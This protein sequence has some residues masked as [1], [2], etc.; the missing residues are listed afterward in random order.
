MKFGN[1]PVTFVYHL[2]V[3]CTD[4]DLLMRSLLQNGKDLQDRKVIVPRPRTYRREVMEALYKHHGDPIPENEQLA[5]YETILKGY[6]AERVILGDQ[7][8]LTPPQGVFE[9]TQL[10]SK[11]GFRSMWLRYLF[12]E[13]P[14]EFFLAIRNPASYLPAAMRQ[15]NMPAY[16]TFV[17]GTDPRKMR[18]TSVV[19]RI[20]KN[21]PD[22][23]IVVWCNE[24]TPL[25]WPKVLREI[26]GTEAEYPF[27]ADHDV[28]KTI[29]REEG[30]EKMQAYLATSPALGESH[31]HRAIA[32]FVDKYALD[33]G[34]EEEIDLPG[35]TPDLVE[36]VSEAYE[37]DVERIERMRDVTFIAP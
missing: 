2:G 32:A 13:N 5:L 34:L 12:P 35:W 10:Y 21:N 17:N 20:R 29:M 15:K 9:H 1:P 23:R 37:T 7:D 30:F 3:H 4:D 11:A 16:E 33:D 22:A 28:L 14:C 6:P 25:I 31:R 24:D 18:W 27:R 26:T 8:Y 36:E 19:E